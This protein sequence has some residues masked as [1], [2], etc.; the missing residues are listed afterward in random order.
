MYYLET[1]RNNFHLKK[2]NFKTLKYLKI[3]VGS[4]KRIKLQF[5]KA[6]YNKKHI[7]KAI[8]IA[9]GIPFRVYFDTKTKHV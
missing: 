1:M 6:L 2:I 5:F 9:Y 8:F 3:H 4:N 7:R